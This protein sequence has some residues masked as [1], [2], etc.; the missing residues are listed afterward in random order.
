M[1]RLK[2]NRPGV[3][4]FDMSLKGNRILEM[5][6]SRVFCFETWH[7]DVGVTLASCFLG[8]MEVEVGRF[9]EGF[10]VSF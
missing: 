5:W 4:G 6:F 7:W 9:G 3:D 2:L 10:V 1:E 8:K